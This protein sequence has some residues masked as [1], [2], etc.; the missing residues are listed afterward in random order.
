MIWIWCQ[1]ICLSVCNKFPR[2]SPDW[3]NRIGWNFFGSYYYYAIVVITLA[4]YNLSLAKS[5]WPIVLTAWF[6]TPFEYWKKKG[7]CKKACIGKNIHVPL[8]VQHYQSDFEVFLQNLEFKISIVH[9]LFRYFFRFSFCYYHVY[10]QYSTL[11]FCLYRLALFHFDFL[12]FD[13]SL[14]VMDYSFQ[15]KYQKTQTG[16]EQFKISLISYKT[17]Y[18]P[19]IYSVLH[20]TLKYS[21]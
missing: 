3:Q 17:H 7:I 2:L 20:T 21:Y 1:R 8:L 11:F 15:L 12:Y 6:T 13:I 5:T 10:V 18:S 9:S 4:K 16:C 14:M 19:F